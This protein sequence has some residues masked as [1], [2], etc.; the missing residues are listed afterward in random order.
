[1]K[2]N[3]K[4]PPINH[5]IWI[6]CVVF[7]NF[8]FTRN[9]AYANRGD[10]TIVKTFS[11]SATITSKGLSTFPNLTLGKPAAIFDFSVG[12]EK[13]RF[14]PTLRFGL[15]GKPWTFIFWLRQ[16]V[17][18]T[19][20]FQLKLGA[21]PA[22]SFRT[23]NISN[24]GTTSEIL[25]TQQFLAFEVAPVFF[26]ARNIS[27]GPY[28]IYS[29]GISQGAVKNSNFISLRTN[30]SNI[31]LSD[32]YFMRLMTQAYY[33]KMDA[34]DGFYVNSTLSLNLRNFPFSVS[35]TINKTIE[36]TIP[37]DGFLWNVNLTY[38]FGGK[39]KK[40]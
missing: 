12:G 6:F 1:M 30:F 10:S 32:T 14:D 17:M 11:G 39:Y 15:D 34:N 19:Q 16:E 9:I 24:N 23:I 31:N 26:I 20:K 3:R 35:S 18:K 28:F 27:F 40:L 33:L 38:S 2:Q 4:L 5:R 13:F 7:A 36:S 22:F 25:R 37:G 21:H 8:L 29:N